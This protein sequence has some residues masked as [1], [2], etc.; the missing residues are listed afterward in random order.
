MRK[1]FTLVELLVVIAIIGLLVAILLPAVQMVRESARRTQCTNNLKQLAMGMLNYEQSFKALPYGC[2]SWSDEFDSSR[3][4]GWYEDHNW[5]SYIMPY[6]EQQAIFDGLDFKVVMSHANNYESRT[7][8]CA[9][10]ACPSDMGQVE[11]EFD[12]SS[13]T[14]WAKLRSNY[15]CNWGN[16]NYGQRAVGSPSSSGTAPTRDNYDAENQKFLGAPF[17]PKQRV[18]ISEL[19]DGTTNTLMMSE[20]LVIPPF[21]TTTWGGPISEVSVSVGG[22]QFSGWFTP[23]SDNGDRISRQKLSDDIYALNNI[24]VPTMVSSYEAQIMTAR[25]HHSG[26]VNTSK[27]DGSVQFVSEDID[28]YLW[29]AY[30]SAAGQEAV[31]S[32]DDED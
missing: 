18:P 32:Q 30:T 13:K 22:Q 19:R 16:T 10:F 12:S 29:R 26:G 31:Y 15:V 25:S 4:I 20:T 28:T 27:C 6:I 21:S 5:Y 17:R 14:Q 23:N 3:S 8:K 2:Y 7:T 1:G 24:P 11:N 9:T